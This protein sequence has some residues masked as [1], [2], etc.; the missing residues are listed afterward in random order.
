MTDVI[1]GDSYS[2]LPSEEM[3]Y[4]RKINRQVVYAG[5]WNGRVWTEFNRI[6]RNFKFETCTLNLWNLGKIL[7]KR[8]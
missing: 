6:K 1:S 7:Q 8:P 5:D 4:V 2:P 3:L